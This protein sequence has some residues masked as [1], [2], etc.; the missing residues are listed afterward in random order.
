MSS[1]KADDRDKDRDGNRDMVQIEQQC[2]Q[3]T[4]TL[5][6]K[7]SCYTRLSSTNTHVHTSVCKYILKVHSFKHGV[8]DM[9]QQQIVIT[10]YRTESKKQTQRPAD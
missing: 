2:N 6:M 7:A 9:A 8:H 3:H 5:A 4:T 1:P 10:D